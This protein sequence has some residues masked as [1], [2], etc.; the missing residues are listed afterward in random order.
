MQNRRRA[1]VRSQALLVGV[2]ALVGAGLPALPAVADE[3]PAPTPSAAPLSTAT[4]SSVVPTDQFIVKF[5]ERAG[6]QS[7]DRQSTLDMA[8]ST[9]G[10]PVEAV[11][12]TG[13][14]EEV[15]RTDRKLGAEEAGELVSALASD[16][17][18]EFAEPDVI[19]RP[20]EFV[21]P[22]DPLTYYQWNLAI[23]GGAGGIGAVGAWNVSRGEGINVAVIDTGI[24]D[25]SD[26]N[27]NILP[28]Y[29]MIS[30][31]E[32]AR[33]GNGRDPYPHDKGDASSAGQ[34]AA[35]EPAQP[36]SWH[37]THVAGIIA[38][39]PNNNQG[40]AGVAPKAKVVPVRALGVCGGYTSDIVDSIIWAAGGKVPNVPTNAN[41]A[42]VINLSLG[43]K[44]TCSV[45][46]QNAVDYA[47]NRGA[48]VVVAAG[49]ESADASK[50]SPANCKNVITVGAS[51]NKQSK[52]YYSN[53]GTSVDIVAP[54]G[55]MTVEPY[56][57]IISTYNAGSNAPS[58]EGYAFMEGTSMAAPHVA[59]T[60]AM[61]FSA[62]PILT[63]DDVEAKI[64]ATAQSLYSCAGGCG[65]GLLNAEQALRDVAADAAPIGTG[66]VSISGGTGVGAELRSSVSGP[67]ADVPRIDWSYQWLRDGTPISGAIDTVYVL[68]GDDLGARISLKVT[69]KKNH[70]ETVTV[71]S[72]PT[73]QVELGSMSN[74]T[75]AS[76]QGEGFVGMTLTGSVG[77]WW[78]VPASL[79]YQ[80]LREGQVIT[81]ATALTYTLAE[82]DV[83]K[84]ISFSVT[85]TKPL[86]VQTTAESE[87]TS[88]IMPADHVVTPSPVV[89]VEAPYMIDDKYIV[90][91]S[92]GVDYQVAG[93]TVK[94]G[95]YPARGQVK[96]TAIAKADYLIAPGAKA[97]WSAFF[98]TKG[99]AYTAP[100][101]SP[102]K[103]VLTTQQFYKEMA[104][105]ADRKI[106]TG[107]VEADKSVTYRPV[108]PINRDAMAAFLYRMAGS[109]AYTPPAKSPFKDVTTTQQFYKEMSWL[110]Q[111]GISSGWTES[112]GSKTY[113][114]LTPIS[115]DAMAAFLYRLAG[116]PEYVPPYYSPFDD[117]SVYQQFYGEMAW[118]SEMKVST[119]WTEGSRR[120]YRPLAPINRDA[121]AA[122]LYRMP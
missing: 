105:L 28:G 103:D 78:P 57:G 75:P 60:L 104:W 31:A 51:D 68:Q 97:E 113:R 23:G 74:Y 38:A 94:A 22:N 64:K 46:Y 13:S 107:W 20:L 45:V 85:A 56:Q 42:R 1:S 101:K 95:T 115:R 11:R 34:C 114:P 66:E 112:D 121:M 116:S 98:S 7:A 59:A 40:M 110:A 79:T 26:L 118:L 67:W 77:E 37:G 6:I 65:A 89:L 14:G 90:P 30:S 19:M 70:F 17:N 53:Y 91:A 4:Q 43:G 35:A 44:A 81:G 61:M 82:A 18:V 62:F 119:G 88:K 10:V 39:I 117:V 86:Y 16:P 21:V 87:A 58:T 32:V 48:A 24:T 55:D 47:R 36:S 27:A 76:L 122:F 93:I 25:H 71:T 52:A 100:A 84:R 106:S 80:W 108:T 73:A 41:P 15:F 72:A 92:T 83:G 3:V 9:V 2:I 63:P 69:A 96:I 49:N 109:P 102:F 54:G 12:S 8:A 120:T 50:F 111:T 29:D 99:P 5:K 33:D